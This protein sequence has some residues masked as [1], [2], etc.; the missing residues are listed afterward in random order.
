M[1]TMKA[2]LLSIA[3]AALLPGPAARAGAQT[4]PP[5]TAPVFKT[6][7][8][9]FSSHDGHAMLGKLTVPGAGGPFPVVVFVQTAEAATADTRIQG[10]K[11]PLDFVDIYR[12]E[13]AAMNVAFF[14][15]EGR[16]ARLGEKPPRYVQ[17]DRAVYNTSTLDN[18]VQDAIT[19]VRLVQK[20]DG[21]DPSQIF[22]HS[23][24][25]GTLL[26]AET[27]ARIPKE[28]KGLVLAAVLTDMKAA[29]KFMM[30]DGV[31]EQ[32]RG[33]WD[34]NRDGTITTAEFDADPRGIRKLMTSG[35]ELARFDRTGDGV[36]TVEDARLNGQPLVN[37]VDTQDLQVLGGWLKAVAMVDTPDGWLADHL[38][39]A[40]TETFLSQLDMPVG[41]FQ[42]EA[43]ALTPASEVRALEQ[44]MKAAGKTKMEFH[45]FP[46]LGHD[47][48]GLR[49]FVRGTPSDA[50]S[51]M[52]D[53]VRRHTTRAAPE[54]RER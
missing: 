31:F 29:M 22:L 19:A 27:A 13:F 26:C 46:G 18:K 7:E 49:Y 8:I 12:R 48:A 54:T 52:F 44:R 3:L 24:S 6:V 25:E 10:P 38:K 47:L 23:M 20:Q 39:H 14:S 35:I 50:F 32:H 2:T 17:L 11:G 40:S 53:F 45:Y 15:Y 34:A 51:A 42:G 1:T 33:H 16:G 36:Y 37:A 43:D 9:P 30:T 5:A 41:F 4:A 21:I 28:I